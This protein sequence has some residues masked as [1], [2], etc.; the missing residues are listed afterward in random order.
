MLHC[1]FAGS[2]RCL[3]SAGVAPRRA[4]GSCPG[5]GGF[6]RGV[7]SRPG[8]DGRR[9]SRS[10]RCGAGSSFQSWG[11]GCSGGCGNLGFAA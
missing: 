3:F 2:S 8:F 9:L 6:G 10:G 4:L 5:G 7:H 11:G 1:F